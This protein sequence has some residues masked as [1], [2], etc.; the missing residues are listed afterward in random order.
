MFVEPVVERQADDRCWQAADDDLAPDLPGVRFFL[1]GFARR[2]RVQLVEI[3]D[4]DG[5]DRAELDDDKEHFPEFTGDVES[6][7]IFYEDH[8]PRAGDWQ[9]LGDPFDDTEYQHF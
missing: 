4:D 5:H 9:P 2:E 6:Q 1:G 7:K 8:V 3:D